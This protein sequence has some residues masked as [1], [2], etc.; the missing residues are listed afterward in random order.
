MKAQSNAPAKRGHRSICLPFDQ[1]VYGE[2][3]ADPKKFRTYVNKMIELFPD[4][5]PAKI[6]NGY[7]LKDKTFR[8]KLG[9]D[10]RRI[11]ID[12]TS[13]T[14]HPSF[15]MPHMTGITEDV[16]GALFLRKFSVPFWALAVVFGKNATYWYRMEKAFGRYNLVATTIRNPEDIPRHLSADEKHTRILAVKAYIAMTVAAECTLGVS[17]S[18]GCG[19]SDLTKA[20][21]VFKAEAVDTNP[22]YESETVNMDGW[23]ATKKAWLSLFPSTTIILCFLHVYIKIRDRGKRKFKEKFVEVSTKLWDCYNAVNKTSFSQ[24]VRRLHEW[25]IKSSLPSVFLDTIGKLRS[26]IN[27]YKAAYD[28]DGD[29]RR[30]SNMLD[31][32]MQRMDLHLISTKYFHGSIDSAE[33]SI[34]A[35]ALI[36]NFAPSN[37]NTLRKYDNGLKSPA[38]RRNNFSYHDSWLQNLL[39]SAY[40]GGCKV[41]SP[42]NP[43]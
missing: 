38:E 36:Q 4:L 19:E 40:R 23:E 5:F 18:P 31:R 43:K 8:K 3:V 12:G 1:N 41:S 30:T 26:R 10:I 28:H 14:L 11:R 13:Y 32:L 15:A 9:I 27:Y 29:V 7:E 34:R 20:Y 21:G 6:V 35:W 33:D 37:P 2:T 16:K 22:A 42:H 17:V 25:G 24:R 39:I